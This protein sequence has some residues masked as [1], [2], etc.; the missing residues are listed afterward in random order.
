MT[1]M[2]S[3]NLLTIETKKKIKLKMNRLVYLGL[4][5]LEVSETLMYEFRY[6]CIKPKY[7]H[8]AKLCYMDTDNF[9]SFILKLK[10]F[11]EILQMMLKKDVIHQRKK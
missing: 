2:F 4:S 1:K 8:Y 9:I 11:K 10:M 3:E 6:D 5:R 7:Q